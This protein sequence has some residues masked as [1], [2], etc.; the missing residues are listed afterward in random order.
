M[1]DPA[2]VFEQVAVVAE[3]DSQH[4]GQGEGEVPVGYRTSDRRPEAEDWRRTG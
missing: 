3:V 2:H 4:L 1:S